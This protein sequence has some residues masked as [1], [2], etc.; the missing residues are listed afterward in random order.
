MHTGIFLALQEPEPMVKRNAM[1][2]LDAF[3]ENL[4][5]EELMPYLAQL[6]T[7][8]GELLHVRHTATHYNTLQQTATHR[9]AYLHSSA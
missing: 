2:A 1:H 4:G 3:C 6:M 8:M 9:E 5:G 7:K